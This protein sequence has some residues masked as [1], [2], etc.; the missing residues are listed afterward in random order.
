MVFAKAVV[1][2]GSKVVVLVGLCGTFRGF[3]VF[4]VVLVGL[5][6]VLPVGSF[7]LLVGCTKVMFFWWV[8]VAPVYQKA[9]FPWP[10]QHSE[11]TFLLKYTQY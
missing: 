6:V 9:P 10:K 5:F 7:V 8:P 1:L 2:V 3:S 4:V 11:T